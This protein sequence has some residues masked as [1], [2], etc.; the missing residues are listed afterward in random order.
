MIDTEAKYIIALLKQV[1]PAWTPSAE[2]ED[3]WMAVLLALPLGT[4]EKAVSK[5]LNTTKRKEPVLG[6][7]W[8]AYRQVSPYVMHKGPQSSQHG[9]PQ[10]ED[11]QAILARL[12]TGECPFTVLRQRLRWDRP[13][14]STPAQTQRIE[15]AKAAIRDF[16]ASQ[17]KA[18]NPPPATPELLAVSGRVVPYRQ[19]RREIDDLL[20][21]GVPGHEL[22]VTPAGHVMGPPDDPQ[23]SADDAPIVDTRDAEDLDEIEIPF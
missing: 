22:V 6:E 23:T 5:L 12:R 20:R 9:E 11:G 1:F 18:I 8:P 4:S 21:D 2:L 7:W 15:S 14:T 16:S 13:D 19:A 10:D 17:H 3:Q